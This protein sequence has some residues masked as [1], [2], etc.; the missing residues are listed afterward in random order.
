MK[1][2]TKMWTPHSGC[3]IQRCW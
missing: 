2:H 1:I 3:Y